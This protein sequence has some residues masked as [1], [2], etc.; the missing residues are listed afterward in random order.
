VRHGREVVGYGRFALNKALILAHVACVPTCAVY[1]GSCSY[2]MSQ[3]GDSANWL[4]RVIAGL[5]GEHYVAY[6]VRCAPHTFLVL[7]RRLYLQ[8]ARCNGVHMTCMA[9]L[10]LNRV[11]QEPKKTLDLVAEL[12]ASTKCV[13]VLLPA[14]CLRFQ[15]HAGVVGCFMLSCGFPFV[16]V[17]LFCFVVI[18]REL[19]WD[20]SS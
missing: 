8:L 18:V 14:Y 1:H 7:S 9:H 11:S 20:R 10:H 3:G 15:P 17:S 12:S 6:A 5:N 19:H 4:C 16:P 2:V 13:H